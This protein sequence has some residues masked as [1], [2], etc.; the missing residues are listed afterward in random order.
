[1]AEAPTGVLARAL[2]AVRYTLSGDMTWFG[3]LTPLAPQAPDDVKGRQWDYPVGANINFTPRSSE[4]IGFDKLKTIGKSELVRMVMDSQKDK[5]E[6]QEWAIKPKELPGG[7]R[8]KMDAGATEIQTALEYPDRIHDWAQWLRMVADQLY[9]LDALSIYRRKDRGG[10]P[11]AFE[12]VDGATIKPLIDGSGRQPIAPSASYQQALKG[13]PAVNYTTDELLYYPQNV[14]VESVYGYSRVEK[15]IETAEISIERMKSQKAFFTH[16]NLSDGFFEAPTGVQ[17]DQV[18]QVE[19]M[20]NNLLGQGVVENRR[21]NQFLPAG[22]KWNAIGQ[23]PLQD[24][25][26]EWLIRIICFNFSVSPQ[27]FLK[28][29]GLGKGSAENE[30]AAAEAAGV[31]NTMT[32]IRRVM[33]RIIAEDF[34]RP[35]LEFDWIEDREFDPETKADIEDKRLRNGSLTLDEVRDR[36]GEEPLPDGEGAQPMV[37][38]ATGPI[39][40]KD[41]LNPP[42]PP[43]TIVAPPQ[44]P[45]G[46]A[47]PKVEQEKADAANLMK[48]APAKARLQLA[49]SRYLAKKG[50]DVAAQVVA[51]LG[52]AKS[53]PMDDQSGRIEQALDDVDWD[54]TDLAKSLTP[55]ITALAT[56]A[57]KD[58]LDDLGLFDKSIM[59]AMTAR[60]TDYANARA[61]EMVGRKLV[62]GELVDNDGWSIPSATRNMVRTAVTRAMAEGE[63]NDGLAAAIRE[64]DAFSR[65][66][67]QMIARTETAKADVAGHR[68]GWKA[69]GLVAGRE[70]QTSDGCCDECQALDGTIVGID[71]E[72]PDGADVPLHPNCECNELPVLPEDMPDADSDADDDDD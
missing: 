55:S 56:A 38:T 69:S 66:R 11:W 60:A 59:S 10:R 13:L 39:L 67:A 2:A 34:G 57:G 49:L 43:P 8:G 42:E 44:D 7:K 17:P 70:W 29:T 21:V 24:A 20:W 64:S 27:P 41:V 62:D 1:M 37:Y 14:R 46:G 63:S 45:N 5:L 16:G 35:D 12:I 48:A 61:A 33:N 15:I 72:F 25:F 68:A 28:Q 53:E 23:P 9:V 40:L 47:A 58:A 6:A 51:S 36:N 32:Y 18:R 50:K 4:R 54:W 30:H 19:T 71:E 52:L 26:D 3:P 31:N 22:F 65:A